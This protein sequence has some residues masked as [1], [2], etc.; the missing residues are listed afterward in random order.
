MLR[1][2]HWTTGNTA[3]DAVGAILLRSDMEL[4]GSYAHSAEKADAGTLAV[5]NTPL[6]LKEAK[7]LP[8]SD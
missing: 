7:P 8:A 2:A 1:I 3:R 5:G 4:V 6:S